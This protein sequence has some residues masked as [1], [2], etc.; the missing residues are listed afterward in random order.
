VHVGVQR[1][2]LVRVEFCPII[3]T[4]IS[5]D[6]AQDTVTA[7]IALIQ[8][9]CSAGGEKGTLEFSRRA[10]NIPLNKYCQSQISVARRVL[11]IY[12]HRLFKEADGFLIMFLTF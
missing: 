5:I 3:L 11:R 1:N 12:R 8:H 10:G 7:A 9:K 4:Q 2:A 6:D